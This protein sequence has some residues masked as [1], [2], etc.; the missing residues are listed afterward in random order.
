MHLMGFHNAADPRAAMIPHH[1]FR[2]VWWVPTPRRIR[3]RRGFLITISDPKS[4]HATPPARYSPIVHHCASVVPT[5]TTPPSYGCTTCRWSRRPQMPAPA[6][7][8]AARGWPPPG[9]LRVYSFFFS[10]PHRYCCS[11][12][13]N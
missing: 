8:R 4:I 13:R 2:C 12:G 1:N 11:S 9:V 10:G 6:D 5:T 3:G 7:S